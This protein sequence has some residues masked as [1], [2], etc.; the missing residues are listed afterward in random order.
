MAA[1]LPKTRASAK[2]SPESIDRVAI[3]NFILQKEGEAAGGLLPQWSNGTAFLFP[4]ARDLS[5]A[6][7]RWSEIH[8]SPKIVLGYDSGDALEQTI[9][10]RIVVNVREAGISLTPEANMPG[11]GII[12]EAR[13]APDPPA[14]AFALSACGAREFSCRDRPLI[15]TGYDPAA[16]R[17]GLAPA[18][19]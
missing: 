15:G 1:L 17:P 3:V 10:E 14:N 12:R 8:G 4:T 13:R 18:N 16:R 6:K 19:L 11:V 7:E 2:R 9:A 5:A